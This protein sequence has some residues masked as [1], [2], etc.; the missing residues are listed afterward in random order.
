MA[1]VLLLA[2]TAATSCAGD[3]GGDCVAV[4]LAAV[5][6]SAAA[7][8]A[9]TCPASVELDGMTYVLWKCPVRRAFLGPVVARGSDYRARSIEDVPMTSALAIRGR[10]NNAGCRGWQFW[11]NVELLDTDKD[12]VTDI[13][14]RVT[15]QPLQ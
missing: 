2:A 4:P 8:R 15:V 11:A 12:T 9:S 7:V 1:L 5:E 6:E 3:D 14:R 13:S 10:P